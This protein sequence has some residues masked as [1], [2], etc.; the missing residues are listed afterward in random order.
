[1][2]ALPDNWKHNDPKIVQ[3]RELR[4]NPYLI[5]F[6]YICSAMGCFR[7]EDQIRDGYPDK[8]IFAP[9]SRNKNI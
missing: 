1:M 3:L 9:L 2:M 4:V 7:A 5:D 6:R 8:S